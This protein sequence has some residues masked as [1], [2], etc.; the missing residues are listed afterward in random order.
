MSATAGSDFK[1]PQ[2]DRSRDSLQ[3]IYAATN[4]LLKTRDFDSITIADISR[5]AGVSV[6]SIYQRFGSKNQLLWSLYEAYVEEA[7][8]RIAAFLQTSG[9]PNVSDRVGALILMLCGMFSDHRGI[10]KSL[11]NRYRAQPDTVPEAIASQIHAAYDTSVL[12]LLSV[13][14]SPEFARRAQLAVSM[15]LA[16]IREQIIYGSALWEDAA[17][18]SHDKLKRVLHPAIMAVLTAP[19]DI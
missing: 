4:E 5:E 8:G 18:A 7:T 3:R 2:Q 9:S 6:G 11:L 16:M 15:I 14:D 13:E 12:Y 19:S 1:V 10:I 17:I